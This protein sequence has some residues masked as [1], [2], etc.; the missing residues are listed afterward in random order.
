MRP[1]SLR[2]EGVVVYAFMLPQSI[3]ELL[4]G[5]CRAGSFGSFG[6]IYVAAAHFLFFFT[7][8]VKLRLKPPNETRG[9]K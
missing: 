1:S 2:G 9:L 5:R 8:I 4:T 6:I 7:Q 3:H